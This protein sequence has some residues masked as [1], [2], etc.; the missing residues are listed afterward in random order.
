MLPAQQNFRV[1]DLMV[2]GTNLWLK[3]DMKLH[4]DCTEN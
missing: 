4:G 1:N 3:D 2:V